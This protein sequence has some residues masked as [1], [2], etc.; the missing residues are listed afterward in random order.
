MHQISSCGHEKPEISF[1]LLL[2]PFRGCVSFRLSLNMI[3]YVMK[4]QIGSK[5][6]L[7]PFRPLKAPIQ[8]LSPTCLNGHL[9][10][11]INR[12]AATVHPSWFLSV[13]EPVICGNPSVD[14]LRLLTLVKGDFCWLMFLEPK[15]PRTSSLISSQGAQEE[16]P[17]DCQC[18]VSEWSFKWMMCRRRSQ[19]PLVNTA[20]SEERRNCSAFHLES[21]KTPQLIRM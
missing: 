7:L 10:P 20:A 1:F 14:G 15:R 5:S 3:C 8:K 17:G 9:F 11:C 12:H 18:R 19:G 21:G 16:S 13:L 6:V 2:C 4:K